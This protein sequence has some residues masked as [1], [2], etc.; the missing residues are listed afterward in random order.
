MQRRILLTTFVAMCA[1]VVA[2][3][4]KA[5]PYWFYQGYLPTSGGAITVLL[6][7]DA[8]PPVYVRASWSSC[9]HDVKAIFIANDGSWGGLRVLLRLRL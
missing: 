4:A 3:A 2:T 1:L 5:D 6:G 8:A 7:Q 9:G